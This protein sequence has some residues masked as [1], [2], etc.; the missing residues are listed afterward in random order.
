MILGVPCVASYVGGIPDL[1]EH[2][3]EGF[4]YQGDA[5]Y[6]LAHYICELF[7]NDKTALDFSG[8]ARRRA[9]ITH[10]KSENIKQ[11]LEVYESVIEKSP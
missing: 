11:L 1:L 3:K 4:L 10:C 5:S 9:Q 6:M 8:S 7:S 2:E